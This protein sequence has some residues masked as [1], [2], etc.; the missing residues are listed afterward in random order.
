M[1]IPLPARR[2]Q[3]LI[4]RLSHFLTRRPSTPINRPRTAPVPHHHNNSISHQAPRNESFRSTAAD[5]EQ[6]C[7]YDPEYYLSFP[8]FDH[9][10]DYT[11]RMRAAWGRA[12]SSSPMPC[13]ACRS[14]SPLSHIANSSSPR[15]IRSPE[16]RGRRRGDIVPGS[17]KRRT[18][19]SS[20]S[21]SLR[22]PPF[23]GDDSAERPTRPRLARP[24]ASTPVLNSSATNGPVPG[25][26]ERSSSFEKFKKIPGLGRWFKQASSPS[27]SLLIASPPTSSSSTP[28]PTS[29]NLHSIPL[30]PRS[31]DHPFIFT[32]ELQQHLEALR[33]GQPSPLTDFHNRRRERRP[34]T[35]PGNERDYA[36]TI[37]YP[38]GTGS[39]VPA[40]LQ[41]PKFPPSRASGRSMRYGSAS[42]QSNAFPG[43]RHPSSPSSSSAMFPINTSLQTTFEVIDITEEEDE[44]EAEPLSQNTATKKDYPYHFHATSPIPRPPS[45]LRHVQSSDD[46][47]VSTLT[48]SASTTESDYTL[49]EGHSTMPPT[50]STIQGRRLEL[51]GGEGSRTIK[52]VMPRLRGG[53]SGDD[54]E[55]LP[56]GLWWLAGGRGEPMTVQG[57]KKLRPR[58]RMGGFLGLVLH[59]KRAGLAYGDDGNGGENTEGF[60][61]GGGGD[62]VEDKGPGSD[63][64][65]GAGSGNCTGSDGDEEGEGGKAASDD[66]KGGDKDAVPPGSSSDSTAKDDGKEPI[67]ADEKT[68]ASDDSKGDKGDEGNQDKA[69]DPA[70][71]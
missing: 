13:E 31:D 58:K 16:R 11:C 50:P 6:P 43:D 17:N 34:R 40:K 24:Y 53:G 8:R 41:R 23:L 12:E 71:G 4:E 21:W 63:G 46:I 26:T 56:H 61:D 3:S 36:D 39:P 49:T 37:F 5:P 18:A 30:L 33:N 69:A 38:R 29:P 66:D 9:Q 35:A 10:H 47:S 27:P 60:V 65:A 25:E 28:R 48:S 57:W 14:Q 51:R 54:E 42:H 70:D 44:I 7:P 1:D 32:R 64:V 59:G 68:G 19:S 55:R 45:G 67:D 15:L 22:F 2:R 20:R 52:N 62:K